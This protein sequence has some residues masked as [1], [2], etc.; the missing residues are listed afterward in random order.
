MNRKTYCGLALSVVSLLGCGM[1]DS[2]APTPVRAKP[3][4]LR[5]ALPAGR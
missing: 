3:A 4:G 1:E 5:T 2:T